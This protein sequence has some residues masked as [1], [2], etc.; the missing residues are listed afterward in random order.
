MAMPSWGTGSTYRGSLAGARE[1]CLS[2]SHHFTPNRSL[3]DRDWLLLHA[4]K[5]YIRPT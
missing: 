4:H 5:G 2:V 3:D 1:V